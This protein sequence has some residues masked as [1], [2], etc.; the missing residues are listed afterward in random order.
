MKK[1]AVA[2][3][4]FLCVSQAV[5]LAGAAVAAGGGVFA[6]VAA[7]AHHAEEEERRD[8]RDAQEI[9]ADA[10][11]GALGSGARTEKAYAKE[12]D[13]R[14]CF[15]SYRRNAANEICGSSYGVQGRKGL[16]SGKALGYPWASVAERLGSERKKK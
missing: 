4:L 14:G 8:G 16:F 11:E 10:I 2:A 15:V 13:R 5:A 3:T 6:R 1:E 9:I 12:L 7:T